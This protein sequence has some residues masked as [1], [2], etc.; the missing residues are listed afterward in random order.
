MKQTQVTGEQYLWDQLDKHI[1]TDPLEDI[2][3]HLEKTHNNHTHTQSKQ[4]K[5]LKMEPTQITH[6]IKA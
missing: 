3:K 2:L 4:L 1:V 6:Q 5:T